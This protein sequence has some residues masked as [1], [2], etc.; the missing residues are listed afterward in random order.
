MTKGC[1]EL[2]GSDPFVVLDS[3]DLQKAVDVGYTSR[4]FNSGQVCISAKRFIVTESVYDEFRDKLVQKIDQATVLGDPLNRETNLG[5]LASDI[6]KQRLMGQVQMALTEGGAQNTH[7]CLDF[8][9]EEKGLED[10]AWVAPIVLENMKTDSKAY[11]EE[12][13]GPVFN[14]FKVKDAGEAY[15]LANKTD[16]GLAATVFTQDKKQAIEAAEAIRAG[17]VFVN[18]MVAS[19]SEFPGGGIKSS[20]YGRECYKDGLLDTGNRKTVIMNKQW[21]N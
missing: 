2:G 16:Y 3:A 19:G 9:M 15:K 12:L 17:T 21:K 4:M 14:L 13:F 8:F 11:E 1:F 7:G 18:D 10:G 5:P 6:Q 20:G